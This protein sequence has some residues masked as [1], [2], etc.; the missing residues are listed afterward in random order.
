VRYC[1]IPC[2]RSDWPRQKPECKAWKDEAIVA[3]GGCPLGDVKAQAAAIEK[4]AAPERTL[5]EIRKAAEGGD[6]AAQY[7]IG[8]SFHDGKKGAP[9]DAAQAL[10]WYRRAAAGNVAVFGQQVAS[11]EVFA[12]SGVSPQDERTLRIPRII[13]GAARVFGDTA[14][15]LYREKYELFAC[16]AF[17]FNY[18]SLRRGEGFVTQKVV[19]AAV[20]IKLNRQSKLL[21]GN[22][23][24][25]RDWGFAGDFTRALQLM[26]ASDAP[27]DYVVATGQ[28]HTVRGLCESASGL[29]GLEY[30]K[31]AQVDTRYYRAD[32]RTLIGGDARCARSELNWSPRVS[33][34]E[35][36]EMIIDIN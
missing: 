28:T 13:Y 25:A 17:L 22:L 18:E 36:I 5:A 16:S 14:V 2:Q 23:A 1:G 6:L 7:V 24:A 30:H 12:A 10:V 33:L 27:R 31:Y 4:W 26:L 15:R 20:R 9:K 19:R 29:L 11:S 32:E 35:I 3:A 21:L 34:G 8:V